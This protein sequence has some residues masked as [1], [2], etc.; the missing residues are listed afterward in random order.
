M[1]CTEPRAAQAEGRVTGSARTDRLKR[2]TCDV[3]FNGRS[4]YR[5]QYDLSCEEGNH[6]NR[7]LV[8]AL[9]KAA[10]HVRTL[11]PLTQDWDL[12]SRSFDGPWSKIWVH[13]D[14][15][16]FNA[17]IHAGWMLRPPS[18][19]KNSHCETVGLSA[20][21]PKVL[22]VNLKGTWVTDRDHQHRLDAEWKSDRCLRL[23]ERGFV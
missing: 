7:L 18:W 10:Q 5:A 3:L 13:D 23:H 8:E 14:R 9:T 1:A 17:A 12:V 20:P 11:R 21:L 2:D 6:F 4:G 15:T 16:H 19:V 22:K